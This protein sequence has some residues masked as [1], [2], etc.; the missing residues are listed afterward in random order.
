MKT[1]VLKDVSRTYKV[2]KTDTFVAL[3]TTNLS[4]DSSGLVSIVGSSGS[5]KSTL[6]NLI[7][8]IDSPSTGEIFL[9]GK[10]YKSI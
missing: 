5:G 7:S 3:A 1:L 4:F 6:I 10:S 8:R 2:D 9:N